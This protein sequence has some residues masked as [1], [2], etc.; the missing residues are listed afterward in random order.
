[1]KAKEL[2][3]FVTDRLNE[4]KAI[5]ILTL[6]IRKLTQIADYMVYAAEPLAAM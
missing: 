2:L 5:D 6:D 3:K 4:K 1:M